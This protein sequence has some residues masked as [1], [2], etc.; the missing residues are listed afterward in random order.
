MTRLSLF[1]IFP[2]D[3]GAWQTL[4]HMRRLVNASLR[5]PVV[6]ERARRIVEDAGVLGRDQANKALAL[7]QWLEQCLTFMPDPRGLELLSTP[8]YLLT[9]IDQR[10]T[11]SGDCDDGAILGAALGKAVGFRA[12]FRALGFGRN[13]PLVHVYTLLN[14]RGRWVNLDTTRSPRFPPPRAARILEVEV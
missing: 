11:V 2:G 10:G 6:V 8:R 7:R 9:Q 5:D 12:K 14:V 4:Q 3:M 13:G 1:T